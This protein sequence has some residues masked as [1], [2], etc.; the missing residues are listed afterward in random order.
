MDG[1]TFAAVLTFGGTTVKTVQL[2]MGHTAQTVTLITYVGYWPTA[3]DQTRTL[4]GSTLGCTHG[5]PIGD[6]RRSTRLCH[7]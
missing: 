2:A 7:R 4:V 3:V 6:T 1:T 5:H